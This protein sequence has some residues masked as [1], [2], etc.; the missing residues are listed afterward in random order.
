MPRSEVSSQGC[1]TTVLAAETSFARAT[2]RSYLV[3]GGAANGPIAEMAPISL[4]LSAC[5]ITFPVL[6]CTVSRRF[7]LAFLSNL[8]KGGGTRNATLIDTEEPGD[9]A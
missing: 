2:S 8:G 9:L 4:S 5:M 1:T 6:R 3:G 7:C